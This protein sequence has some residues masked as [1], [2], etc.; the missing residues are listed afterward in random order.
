MATGSSDPAATL[1]RLRCG[2]HLREL[3]LLG[4]AGRVIQAGQDGRHRPHGLG[5]GLVLA[6]GLEP[7][8]VGGRDRVL[9]AE[10]RSET[11]QAT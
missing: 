8:L 4:R 6:E 3:R 9:Q 10:Q 2:G 1:T 5:R 7:G 11:S